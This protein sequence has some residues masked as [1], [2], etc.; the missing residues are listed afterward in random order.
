MVDLNFSIEKAEAVPF[1]A[2]PMLEFSLAIKDAE[3]QPV[4]A[5]ALRFAR[6]SCATDSKRLGIG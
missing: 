5:V 4:H 2:A 3:S 1:A 6:R